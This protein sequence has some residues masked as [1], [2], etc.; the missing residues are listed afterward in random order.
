MGR[1]KI[2]EGTGKEAFLDI[3]K[4]QGKRVKEQTESELKKV[5]KEEDGSSVKEV[6]STFFPFYI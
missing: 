3:L 6:S 5:K 2:L 4:Q 1:E